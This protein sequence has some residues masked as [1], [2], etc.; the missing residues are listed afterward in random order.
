[1]K[2]LVMSDTHGMLSYAEKVLKDFENQ[3]DGF[4]HL[5][6]HFDD[7]LML[8]RKY[9][10]LRFWAVKGNCDFC[11]APTSKI[12]ELSDHRMYI[13]HGHRED[14]KYDRLRLVYCAAENDCDIAL[15]G[16]THVPEIDFYDGILIFNPGSLSLPR[17]GA[18]KTFGLLDITEEGVE[19]SIYGI[20]KNE[21]KRLEHGYY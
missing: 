21:Y 4:M 12:G 3:I 15:Y 16:H 17:Q 1:M 8:R 7:A 11:K 9:L 5:G 20:Y 18:V 2:I 19:A 10:K 13:C 14:V 6:D